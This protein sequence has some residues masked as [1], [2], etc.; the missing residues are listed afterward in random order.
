M[1]TYHWIFWRNAAKYLLIFWRNTAKYLLNILAQCSK[2]S[3]DCMF[4]FESV[5][6]RSRRFLSEESDQGLEGN[7]V[8]QWV[9][10][11]GSAQFLSGVKKP[12]PGNFWVQKGVGFGV[13]SPF[14]LMDNHNLVALNS[15]STALVDVI[16][17]RWQQK[18][19]VHSSW[20]TDDDLKRHLPHSC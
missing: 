3:C 15:D 14:S 8:E 4:W 17:Q 13:L 10:G 5:M 2:I 20:M 12:P 1:A 6:A 18:I 16:Y 9:D 7:M 19:K 11:L